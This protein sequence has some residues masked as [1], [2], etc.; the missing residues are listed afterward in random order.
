MSTP[1]VHS[2]ER[3]GLAGG[4]AMRGYRRKCK[5]SLKLFGPDP[6]VAGSAIRIDEGRE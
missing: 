1:R 2:R 4:D 5:C 3:Q 6:R